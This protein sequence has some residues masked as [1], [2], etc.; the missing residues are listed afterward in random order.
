MSSV[1]FLRGLS[2]TAVLEKRERRPFFYWNLRRSGRDS[3]S[4]SPTSVVKHRTWH[5]QL[6]DPLKM[7][8]LIAEDDEFQAELLR[9]ALTEAGYQVTVARTGHQALELVRSGG[10]QLVVSDWEMPGLSGVELCREIRERITSTYV[11]VILLT[12]R[13]GSQNVIEGLAAGADDFVT[14]P[15]NGPELCVR[16]RNAERVL[17]LQSRELVIFA[18]AKLAESRDTDTGAHLERIREYCRVLAECLGRTP[19]YRGEIDG[20]YVRLIYLTSPLHDIG[21]V[22]IPDSVLLKPG[23]LTK[24]EFAIMQRHPQIGAETLD[25]AV[26]SY[27]EAGF[28]LM[29]SDIAWTHHE[30]FDGSGYPRGLQGTEI[31]LC[32]RIVAIADV[33]D[34]LTTRRVYKDAYS[35]EVAKS[36][37]VEGAGTHFDPDVVAAF[38]QCESDFLQIL[39]QF[40]G[41]SA[42]F[43][44]EEYQV[45]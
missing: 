30:K 38:L 2:S 22:G 24:E 8:V 9:A 13:S 7:H 12:S 16:L 28:L 43:V 21:K 27:Q 33:Y 35:P 19:K 26:A 42:E 45:H 31:P 25:A 3:S 11:Y 23:R 10:F 39:Y 36:I 6:A 34:A 37:I 18:L 17:T 44:D 32:G 1:T 29:A 4:A 20:E 5:Y 14:K 40:A 15:F 41:A